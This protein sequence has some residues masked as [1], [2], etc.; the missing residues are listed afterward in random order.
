MPEYARE[1]IDL[2]GRPY[3]EADIVAIARGQL[4]RE[5]DLERETNSR[6]EQPSFL[7]VDTEALV[8]KI[9]SEVKYRR[10]D[11]WILHQVESR[12]YDLYLLCNIDIP[13]EYD[14][15]REH[16][17][18][19]EYLFNLYLDELIRRERNFRVVT[20][21]GAERLSNAIKFI[22]ESLFERSGQ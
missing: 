5:K 1:Y 6:P 19:R 16:P 9:W 10:C 18:M 13:W 15:Q 8:T 12:V 2:L 21:L 4:Q 20:G 11:P 17:Q 22:D 7:F 3:G 14:P